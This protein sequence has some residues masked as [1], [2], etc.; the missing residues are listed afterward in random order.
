MPHVEGWVLDVYVESD[1]AVLWFKTGDGAA[2][3]LTDRY[4]PNFYIKPKE[5]TEVD[6]LISVLKTHPHILEAEE[7]TKYTSLKMDRSDIIHIRVDSARNLKKMMGDLDKLGVA[8]A[9]FNIDLLHVQYYLYQKHLPPTSKVS[10]SYS[11]EGE[12]HSAEVLDDSSEMKPPP[13]TALI[14][15]VQISSEKLSPNV[16]TDPISKIVVY[17]EDL[18]PIASFDGEEDLL[19]PSFEKHIRTIDPDFLVSRNIEE[20]LTYILRRAR[21]EGLNLQI[22]REAVDA[23]RL[24]RLLPYA[25]RGRVCLDLET[26]L[27]VGLEGVVERSRFTFA[28]PG[29]A[30]EW[31]AG[32]TIDSRQ[33]YEA[34]RRGILIPK[35]YG[36]YQYSGTLKEM[37]FRDRGGLILS[38]KVGLHE[39]VGELDF[40]SM[41]PNIIIKYNVSYET[42]SP[43]GIERSR[44]GFLPSLTETVLARRLNFKHLRK[45][46]PKD[47]REWVWC[48]HRQTSLKGIL[49]CIYGYSGCF[50]NRFSNVLCYEEINRLA[51]ENLVRAMNIALSEGFE[52]I[53]GDSDS[54]FVKRKNASGKD[55]E[56]L[57]RKI[58]AETGLPIALDHHYKFLALLKQE[59]DPNLE[60][61]RRYFGKLVDGSIYYRGIELRRHD[62]PAF[63]KDFEERLMQI[64]F[65]AETA[66]DVLRVQ[67]GKSL[68]YVVE[69]CDEIMAGKVPVEDLIVKK[70][71]RR[72]VGEYRSL[73]PHVV[74]AI[75]AIQNGKRVRSGDEIDFVYLNAEHKNP[76]RRVVPAE[77]MKIS[78]HYDKEKYVELALD[79]AE[80]VLGVFGFNRK[81]LGFKSKP[82]NYVEEL[83]LER[84]N[85]V[86]LE[87]DLRHT[88][89]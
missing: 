73:F 88:E 24:K 29:L 80:T 71:L 70:V 37:I 13:F 56:D 61:T 26:F 11:D 78:Q 68:D 4:T 54:L 51:R 67:Y 50:A 59:S 76:F 75:Q 53:Y 36:F 15:D 87:P 86:F 33:C 20:T 44:K 9:Y 40:E 41:F 43:E 17:N 60:A 39:N 74:A 18:E 42:V 62:Y 14:F 65:D 72:E 25:H 34:F 58:E 23:L 31:P 45:K 52:V 10:I 38:P 8:E 64:L 32:R 79:V 22:G 28:P 77:I 57:A 7:E 1:E 16:E 81:Q 66:D 2:V 46:F 5:G 12:L 82:K 49:V 3:R 83:N 30:A 35:S 47:S 48:D 6:E 69:T 21:I 84:I 89:N 55:F 19:L 27:S 85:E 63:M